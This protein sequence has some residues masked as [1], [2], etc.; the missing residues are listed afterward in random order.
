MKLTKTASGQ[1]KLSISRKEWIRIGKKYQWLKKAQTE[2]NSQFVISAQS[3][4]GVTK[5]YCK[6]ATQGEKMIPSALSM[7]YLFAD[8]EKAQQKMTALQQKYEGLK[9]WQVQAI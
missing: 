1:N 5:Y 3:I 6:N 7:A 2:N 4:N 9:N 8:K